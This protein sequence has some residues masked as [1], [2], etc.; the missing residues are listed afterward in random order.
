MFLQKISLFQFKNYDELNLEFN[1]KINCI[2]GNNGT[3]KTNLLD[4]IYYLSFAKSA[5]NVSDNQSISFNRELF[6][7]RG[8]F[9]LNNE[10][11]D[12]QFSFKRGQ[13]KILKRNQIEYLRFSEHIGLLPLV[14][15]S[16]NDG[17]LI[18]GGSDQRRKFMDGIISQFYPE[19]LNHLLDY[20]RLLDQRNAC[21]KKFASE[22]KFDEAL[23]EVF[24]HQLSDHGRFLLDARKSFLLEFTPF[25][26]DVHHSLSGNSEPVKLNYHC[27]FEDNILENALKS[28]WHKDCILEH[29]SIGPHRDDLE[30]LLNEHPLKRFASQGQQKTWLLALKLAQYYYIRKKKSNAPLLLLD[31]IRDKL[32]P[33][34]F[35]Q[36]LSLISSTDFGQVFITDSQKDWA[37]AFFPRKEHCSI[38]T[39]NEK[40]TVSC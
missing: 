25:F 3:G 11:E 29:T 9:K 23:I 19:Y 13:K 15:I 22:R 1:P 36:L 39:M 18:T 34:R 8:A 4:A 27:S 12:I 37:S 7:L 26:E 2:T 5:L 32:D 21:L 40:G 38:F 20:N 17:L 35:K 31:D 6:M 10:E 33:T 28:R 14:M 16:P 30:F 24:D